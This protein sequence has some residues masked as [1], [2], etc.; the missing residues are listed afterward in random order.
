ME[1]KYCKLCDDLKPISE[2][3]ETQKSSVCKYHHK[4]IGKN[5]KKEYRKD[6]KNKEKER[7]KYLERKI[8]LWANYL[9]IN[10]K[11]RTHE[12]TI[13]VE[14]II[15][16]YDKQN[17]LCFWFNVPLHPTLIKKHPQNPSLDRLDR[18]KGYT[19]DNV[20][21]CCYAANIGRNETTVEIWT[22]FIDVLFNKTNKTKL[23]IDKELEILNEKLYEVDSKDEYVIYD[24]EL[25]ITI[26]K[27]LRQ[28]CRDN[29]ISPNTLSSV[30]KKINRK[31][32]KGMI[33]LN[34]TKNESIEKRTYKLTSP[35]G[36]NYTLTSLRDFCKKNNLNDSAL[37][38]V[39]K[40]EL[41]NYKGWKCEYHDVILT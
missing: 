34:R 11:H 19:K 20:V 30:R 5:R 12:N 4:E 33:I 31:T 36:V 15:D 2:F 10:T 9:L 21:L 6:P 16:I 14:D 27:N 41:N 39:G 28:Y 25:N 26:V 29:N 3:Y 13:T 35:E 18:T 37:H 24:D 40:G 23:Q 32:Q 1:T 22:D 8:R 38:K 17:G 7:L